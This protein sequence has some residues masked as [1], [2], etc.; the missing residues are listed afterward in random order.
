MYYIFNDLT[1]IDTKDE[2]DR[3]LN[4]CNL[5]QIVV[6]E[7]AIQQVK[8][9]IIKGYLDDDKSNCFGVAML[10]EGHGLKPE[11]LHI[12]DKCKLIVGINRNVYIIDYINN[13]V[14]QIFSFETLFYNFLQVERYK[15]IMA[16][17]ETGVVAIN[18]NFEVMWNF[19]GDI[20]SDYQIVG[21]LLNIDFYDGGTINL[22]LTDGTRQKH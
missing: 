1:E 15:I 9:F 4:K 17:Y 18:H 16:I 11:V 14:E 22:S 21:N 19:S 10:S 12:H 3:L 5:G 6:G 20:I 13:K 8:Y 2:L 7:N